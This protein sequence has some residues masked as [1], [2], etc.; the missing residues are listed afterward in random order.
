MRYFLM[1]VFVLIN[2]QAYATKAE[3]QSTSD[4]YKGIELAQD[5]STSD[6]SSEESE[7]L[8][9]LVDKGWIPMYIDAAK[10]TSEELASHLLMLKEHYGIDDIISWEPDPRFSSPEATWDTYRK[11][12]ISGDF[13]LALRCLMPTFV[14]EQSRLFNSMGKEKMKQLAENM[15]PIERVS[16]DDYT[17][18]YRIE[19]REIIRG[20]PYDISYSI[21]FR[22]D[23]GEWRILEF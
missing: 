2:V 9:A 1:V 10:M 18:E 13:E 23:F 12:L 16:G 3:D 8:K 22:R 15:R 21:Y 20:E 4:A 11:A 7:L 6:L 19:K 14:E 17:I 5:N